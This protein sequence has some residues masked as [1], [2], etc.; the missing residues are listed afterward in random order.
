MVAQCG[1]VMDLGSVGPAH[2]LLA[3]LKCISLLQHG[4][5]ITSKP[6]PIGPRHIMHNNL[7]SSFEDSDIVYYYSKLR[8]KIPSE[9]IV[10]VFVRRRLL[11]YFDDGHNVF[12]RTGLGSYVC[13]SCKRRVHKDLTW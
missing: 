3:Q 7:K 11:L 6:G 2:H 8:D 12:G 5:V 13:S 10:E 1:Q 9:L 4:G